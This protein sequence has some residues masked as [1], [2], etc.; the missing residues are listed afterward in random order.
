MKTLLKKKLFWVRLLLC[1]L[2]LFNLTAIYHFSSQNGTVSA[3]TSEK[4]TEAMAQVVIKDLSQKTPSDRSSMINWIENSVRKLAHMVEFGSLAV[5]LCLL[6]LT[7]NGRIWPKGL[8]SLGITALVAVLDEWHQERVSGRSAKLIDVGYDL[9]GAILGCALL[10]LLLLLIRHMK[11][12]KLRLKTTYY[13]LSAPAFPELRLRLALV[14]DLHGTGFDEALEL[15]EKEAPDNILIPGDVMEDKELLDPEAPGYTFLKRCAALAP[16]Y[17]SPGNHEIGCYHKG[18]PWRHP[19]PNPL[20][21]EVKARIAAT[22][23][24]LL[25][26]DCVLRE[27]LCFCGLTSG[28]DREKNIPNQAALERFAKAPGF[29]ILLCHHPEYFVPYIQKTGIELTVCGHAHGGQWRFFG[30][31]VYAPGQGILPK[32]T[33]GVL[34][35][36]CVISRGIGNHTIYPRIFNAPELVMICFGDA[37]EDLSISP[38]KKSKK[39]R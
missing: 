5:L 39:R 14:S 20:P 37:A 22:G 3:N 26:N 13:S 29:R 36:R 17:Y 21:A 33:S 6:L 25:D 1:L 11:Q 30:R 35:G 28:I 24:T 38:K 18:N 23:V 4:V 10:F 9:L 2:I 34:D 19:V 31:G 16:T 12:K 32:Y 27:G 8:L 15:L 7:W